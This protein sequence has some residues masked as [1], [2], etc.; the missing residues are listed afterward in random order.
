MSIKG[1]WRKRLHRFFNIENAFVCKNYHTFAETH[2]DRSH[3]SLNRLVNDLSL[4]DN[5]GGEAIKENVC[6]NILAKKFG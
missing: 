3:G 5:D 4:T 2:E 1:E 6:A